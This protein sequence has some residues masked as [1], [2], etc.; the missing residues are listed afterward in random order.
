VPPKKKKIVLSKKNLRPEGFV[1][2]FCQTFKE[3]IPI[4]KKSF[5]K[6]LKRKE[7]FQTH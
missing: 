3:I 1:T 2:E 5:P 4:F 7:F 6:K